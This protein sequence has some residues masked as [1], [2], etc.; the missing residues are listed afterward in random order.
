MPITAVEFSPDGS[1]LFV[2]GYHEITVWNPTDGKL[3]RRIPGIG[4]RTYAIRFS[5][6]G[7]L[8]TSSS[9]D[10]TVRLWDVSN[11]QCLKILRGHGSRVYSVTFNPSGNVI[12]SDS[13]D[14]TIK[15][16]DVH[17]GE[18]IRT[19]ISDRPYERMNI[20]DVRGL[21]LAQKAMLRAL[22]AIEISSSYST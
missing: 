20:T 10:Q 12:A 1:Q 18:C 15:L 21:T 22:G 19:F 5:P 17:N 11:E 7:K 14:G 13:E 2:G 4:Q 8:L 16:W 9:E 3:I 6:D